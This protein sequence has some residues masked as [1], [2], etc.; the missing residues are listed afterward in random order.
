M[1]FKRPI[2]YRGYLSKDENVEW[3]PPDITPEEQKTLRKKYPI[4]TERKVRT[5]SEKE[6]LTD[7]QDLQLKKPCFNC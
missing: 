2:Y 3:W 1:G 6:I 4:L 5:I 7:F